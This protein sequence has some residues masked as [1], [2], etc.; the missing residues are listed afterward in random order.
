MCVVCGKVAGCDVSTQAAPASAGAAD[1]QHAGP[2]QSASTAAVGPA[3]RR[4]TSHSDRPSTERPRWPRPDPAARPTQPGAA[5]RPAAQHDVSPTWWRTGDCAADPVLDVPQPRGPGR[6]GRAPLTA[7]LVEERCRKVLRRQRIPPPHTMEGRSAPG[8]KT[9][10][11]RQ[12]CSPP[13]LPRHHPVGRQ[14][15]AARPR[16]RS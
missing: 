5:A 14:I 8:G 12:T 9:L 7:G 13:L 11:R 1:V 16:R 15:Y 10:R 2:V 6:R 4:R 3:N